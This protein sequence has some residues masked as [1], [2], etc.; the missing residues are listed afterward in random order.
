[1]GSSCLM[2]SEC[3]SG[4]MERANGWMAVMVA[5]QRECA[6]I[7]VKVVSFMLRVF[8]HS[9][10]QESCFFTHTPLGGIACLQDAWLREALAQDTPAWMLIAAPFEEMGGGGT[11]VFLPGDGGSC[12]REDGPPLALWG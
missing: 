4:K 7:M 5:Q 8:H 12:S 10:K 1:M 3:Q 6:L 11:C 2:N 9:F